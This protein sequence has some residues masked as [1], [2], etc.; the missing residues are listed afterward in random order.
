M[1][2]DINAMVRSARR[3]F[4]LIALAGESDC[5][6]NHIISRNTECSDSLW[7]PELFLLHSAC[8]VSIRD[9]SGNRVIFVLSLG[10]ESHLQI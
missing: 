4:V 10:L 7:V 2:A 6:G 9:V 8:V 5:V 1:Q 3:V